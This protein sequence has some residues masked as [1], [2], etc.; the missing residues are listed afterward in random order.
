MR[1]PWIDWPHL[2]VRC[3]EAVYL[4]AHVPCQ[5]PIIRCPLA[6]AFAFETPG[7]MPVVEIPGIF[8]VA[9]IAGEDCRVLTILDMINHQFIAKLVRVGTTTPRPVMPMPT[10]VISACTKCGTIKKSGKRSC[11]ARGG[12]W[13]KNCGDAGDTKFDHTWVQG[14]Q[15]CKSAFLLRVLWLA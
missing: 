14:I 15:A 8:P 5:S 13:F 12:A 2:S 10:T 1:R 11:C 6:D 9:A 4:R 7:I 3:P